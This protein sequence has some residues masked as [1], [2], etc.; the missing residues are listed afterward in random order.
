MIS[1]P[2]YGIYPNKLLVFG[3]LVEMKNCPKENKLVYFTLREETIVGI[4]S[5][6]EA[7]QETSSH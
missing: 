5:W 7:A 1:V 4:R 2:L 6:F 3:V